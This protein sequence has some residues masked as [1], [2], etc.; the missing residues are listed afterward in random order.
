MSPSLRPL[1]LQILAAPIDYDTGRMGQIVAVIFN[2][3]RTDA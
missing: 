3:I 2:E 1:V